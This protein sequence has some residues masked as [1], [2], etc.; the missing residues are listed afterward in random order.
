MVVTVLM[1]VQFPFLKYRSMMN[2]WEKNDLN[3]NARFLKT[4]LLHA[5]EATYVSLAQAI[6]VQPIPK[7]SEIGEVH[8]RVPPGA[9][10][11]MASRLPE[12]AKEK[13]Y[14]AQM[15]YPDGNWESVDFRMRGRNIW[16]WS[17]DKPS[18]R[19][20]L[21]KNAPLSLQRHL[22]FVN[23]EDKA[24]VSNIIGEE[25]AG[26]LGVLTHLSKPV[27]LFINGEYY[28]F[29]HQTTREDEEMLRANER[30]PGPLF[31]GDYLGPDWDARDFEVEGNVDALKKFSPLVNMIKTLH[32]PKSVSK[33]KRLWQI[34]SLEKLAAWD[35]AMKLAGSVHTDYHHNNLFYY[36]PRLGRVEPIVSDIN[37]HGLMDYPGGM[38]RYTQAAEP[39]FRT[40]INE[41]LQPLT[42]TA[43]RDPEFLMKRNEIL[44]QAIHNE[45]SAE[46]QLAF[47]KDY[48]EKIDPHV[49]ADR[50]K[51]ALEGLVFGWYRM[52]FAN[53]QYEAAKAALKRWIERRNQFLL[54]TLSDTAVSAQLAV[55]EDESGVSALVSVSGNA[56]VVFD[57][58]F[59]G[60]EV[61][62]DIELNGTYSKTI[63]GP[64]V[65]APGLYETT[66]PVEAGVRS[67][68]RRS[69]DLY[70]IG[71]KQEYAFFLQGVSIEQAVKSMTTAFR[72]RLS[73]E[74]IEP[75]IEFAQ[76]IRVANPNENVIHPWQFGN[77]KQDV[78]IGEGNHVI[79]TDI[80]VGADSRL[81]I[82]AGA[83]LLMGPGVSI[84]SEGIVEVSGTEIQ[85]VI[86]R[87]QNH[88]RPWGGFLIL[89]EDANGSIIRHADISGG[90]L[91]RTTT[92]ESSG[93]V[94]VYG[95]ENSR[96]EH[97]RLS[98][99]STSDDTLHMVYGTT[100][101]R[102]I[103]LID[104]FGDCIDLDFVTAEIDGITAF[105]PRNDGVDFM[106]SKVRIRD[107]WIQ[108]AGDKGLSVGELSQVAAEK[109]IIES[110][111]I[112]VA[113][114][115]NSRI[116][117]D[118]AALRANEV[119]LD[120]YEKNWRYGGAGIVET[121]NV[122]FQ[123]NGLNGR[124]QTGGSWI[125]YADEL[126]QNVIQDGN[127]E[128]RVGLNQ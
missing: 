32:E 40:P 36:D 64:M 52:P 14:N 86:I 66:D 103:E 83:K 90:S 121:K 29:Y 10:K 116:S 100:A 114:K 104:C 27:R 2:A 107:V 11:T 68:G 73:G 21:K 63:L 84:I 26:R 97:I 35:A 9:I 76:H 43:L 74:P 13:F 46:A 79:N 54:D 20:K 31:V 67:A 53:H 59:S 39:D 17:P 42:N 112:G 89:G 44:Y 28:G 119:A 96:L 30:V 126:P 80:Y 69:P 45:A 57:P 47:L 37:G 38:L 115:D 111:S 82:E 48:Y 60:I 1:T 122:E 22:N 51:G 117:I 23:P 41:R 91:T 110:A 81:V 101:I 124:I 3:E 61:K 5:A 70:L 77:E 87:R 18:L 127:V 85:P 62:A 75:N 99:N 88:E 12:S 118:G 105:N 113:I 94:S 93:M 72:H 24:M 98:G 7:R 50:N 8:L 78:V 128:L 92:M 102:D 25:M 15:L 34:V 109:I 16:H 108:N 65:L 123:D 33:Y 19:V 55:A 71:G 49:K 56:S 120:S 125:I 95:V 6:E 4:T 106:T 58:A